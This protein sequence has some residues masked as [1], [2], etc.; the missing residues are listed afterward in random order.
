MKFPYVEKH[1]SSNSAVS[2]YNYLKAGAEKEFK[3]KE[4]ASEGERIQMMTTQSNIYNS[5]S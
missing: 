2:D 5:K 3:I 4:N 1:L